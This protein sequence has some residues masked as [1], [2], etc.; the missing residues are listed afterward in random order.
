MPFENRLPKGLLTTG[1]TIVGTLYGTVW[2]GLLVLFSLGICFVSISEEVHREMKYRERYGAEWRTEFEREC[3][4]VS[5][6]RIRAGIGAF[7]VVAIPSAAWFLYRTLVPSRRRR[8]GSSQRK[9]AR[10][11]QSPA[12]RI[13]RYRRNAVVGVYYGLG[14]IVA[15]VGLV[16]FRWRIFSDHIYEICLGIGL[17]L[18]GYSAVI[19]GCYWWLK[20]KSWNEAIVSIGL[21][22]LAIPLIPFVRLLLLAS[23]MF[24]P[25]AMVMMP[26]I[27][28]VV[29]FALPNRT[30]RY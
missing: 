1:L 3:G 2:L 28:V 27:L 21:T 26:L 5:H 7:G 16:I 10:P 18:C 19:A 20:A 25:M 24:L 8:D 15:G 4:P 29:V 9:K 23:P 12:E 30:R 13:A 11:H 22:P 6:A 14:G 17:F